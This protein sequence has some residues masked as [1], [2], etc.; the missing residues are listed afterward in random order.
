MDLVEQLLHTCVWFQV[1]FLEQFFPP[2]L[3]VP[4]IEN[5]KLINT[6]IHKQVKADG[7]AA[8][9]EDSLDREASQAPS[10]VAYEG[11]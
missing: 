11:Q 8:A 5:N 10:S 2:S 3:Q 6:A 9:Q 7:K 1:K 4:Y